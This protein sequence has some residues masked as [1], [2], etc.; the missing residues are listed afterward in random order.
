MSMFIYEQVLREGT[1]ILKVRHR[2]VIHRAVDS[3]SAEAAISAT[4][5]DSTNERDSLVM[6]F[7][8]PSWKTICL[9]WLIILTFRGRA[10]DQNVKIISREKS[11]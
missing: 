8:F 10:R 6:A 11:K 9:A 4:G 2:H 1:F 5:G 3:V 7:H